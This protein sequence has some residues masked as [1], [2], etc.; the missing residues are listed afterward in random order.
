MMSSLPIAPDESS[1]V[2]MCSE[3]A[4]EHWR[5][6]RDSN[7]SWCVC[8][9]DS[10]QVAHDDEVCLPRIRKMGQEIAELTAELRALEWLV[11]R[12]GTERIWRCKCGKHD[13]CTI[14]DPAAENMRFFATWS[15]AARA[16][17]WEE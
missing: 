5:Q 6:H 4:C 10:D 15:A 12:D 2:P 9:E 1:G 8:Q 14:S 11:S 16:L 17:G 3:S 7:G 13:P